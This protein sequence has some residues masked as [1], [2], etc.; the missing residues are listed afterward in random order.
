MSDQQ[1]DQANGDNSNKQAAAKVKKQAA[2]IAAS[3]HRITPAAA[4]K[5]GLD[6]AV[7]GG[8]SK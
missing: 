2:A 6:P 8:K 5:I 3:R 4:K 1:K 7:Y